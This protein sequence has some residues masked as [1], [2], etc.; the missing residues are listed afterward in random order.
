MIAIIFR[1]SQLVGFGDA[2]QSQSLSML[3][4]FLSYKYPVVRKSA[5]ENLYIAIQQ[6]ANAVAL[7][8]TARSELEQILLSGKWYGVTLYCV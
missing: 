3:M 1:F 4:F 8:S 6:H 2:I 7:S 5:G